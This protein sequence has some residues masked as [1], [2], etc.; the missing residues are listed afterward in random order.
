MA[1]VRNAFTLI[2]LLV[3]IAIIAILAAILFP[4]FAQAK[5]AAK[6]TAALSN[7]K[8]IG[9][10]WWIYQ[11][12]FDDYFAP[13][14]IPVGG[15][16]P[17]ELSWKQ[18]LHPYVKNTQIY[19]DPINPASKYPDDCSDDN[20]RASWGQSVIGPKM[21]RGYSYYDQAWFVAQ[22]WNAKVYSP[23]QLENTAGVI[24][25]MET[26]R[27]WVDAGPWLNWDKNDWDPVLGTVAPLGY[28]WGGKKW[29]EKAMVI[30]YVDG[31][32][33]RAAHT[34][35][36]GKDDELNAWN[37]VRNKL[38]TGYALGDL[39]WVDTYCQTMPADVK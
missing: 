2:E 38:A 4:V 18:L 28:P 37:Y 22:D 9:T 7:L 11:G 33:K 14:R 3:V 19:S 39:S 34:A 6:T 15:A 12:D 21:A 36:C 32:A 25:I 26:K 30:S 29:Q 10:S 31:H 13:R 35:I 23:T 5:Q 17:G 20:L 24:A 8:Q 27:V 16:T 1:R